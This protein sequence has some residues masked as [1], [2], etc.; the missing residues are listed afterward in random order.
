VRVHSAS[1]IR[2]TVRAVHLSREASPC[3]RAVQFQSSANISTYRSAV[4]HIGGNLVAG[5]FYAVPKSHKLSCQPK[6]SGR[7]GPLASHPACCPHRSHGDTASAAGPSGSRANNSNGQSDQ[8]PRGLRWLDR[9]VRAGT[10]LSSR[11]A[12]ETG[13]DGGGAP[14]KS[15]AYLR[16]Y[17]KKE[18]C[19][20][21][22]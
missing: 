10:V 15:D 11:L 2:S 17:S 22:V 1:S 4:A 21:I 3:S 5:A 12:P 14:F 20:L 6:R 19:A 7:R 16:S 8:R 9:E 18:R 13:S